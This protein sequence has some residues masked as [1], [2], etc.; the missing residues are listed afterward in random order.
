MQLILKNKDLEHISKKYHLNHI[1]LFGSVLTDAFHEASD[2]DIAVAAEHI[3]SL[4]EVLELELFFEK[5]FDR[6]VDV[7]DLRNERLD[8]FLKINILNT[9]KTIYTTDANQSLE[10]IRDATEWYYRENETFF[11]F[12]R[13]D[14]LS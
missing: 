11:F 2:I 7:I 4:N 10:E 14:L 6:N 1:M 5:Q 3:L 12:R 9:G 8:I 13:R